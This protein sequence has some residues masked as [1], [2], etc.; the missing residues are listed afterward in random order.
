[1]SNALKGIK[2]F[3][4]FEIEKPKKCENQKILYSLNDITPIKLAICDKYYYVL[5]QLKSNKQFGIFRIHPSWK[6]IK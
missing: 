2:K 1:M 5:G 4:F 3:T 6:I